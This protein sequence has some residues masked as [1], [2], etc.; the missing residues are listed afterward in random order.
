MTYDSVICD[1]GTCTMDAHHVL[2]CGTTTRRVCLVHRD[3]AVK[4]L[5]FTH[6]GERIDIESGPAAITLSVLS[7]KHAPKGRR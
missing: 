2:T 6:P 7:E 1:E 3:T 4:D 5:K